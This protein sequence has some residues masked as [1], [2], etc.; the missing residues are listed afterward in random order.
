[1][2]NCVDEK[3]YSADVKN[4]MIIASTF[5]YLFSLFSQMFKFPP[6]FSILLLFAVQP[7]AFLSLMSII[8]VVG[9]TATFIKSQQVLGHIFHASI[10]KIC[11]CNRPD[12]L[13]QYIFMMKIILALKIILIKNNIEN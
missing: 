9:Q 12:E 11:Y 6:I 5:L 10:S 2:C 4:G 13:T 1:M 3:I 8:V 7:F